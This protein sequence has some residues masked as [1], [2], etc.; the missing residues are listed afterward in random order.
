M[1]QIL[2]QFNL[3][4]ISW[5]WKASH[6][7]CLLLAF[8]TFS[9]VVTLSKAGMNKTVIDEMLTLPNYAEEFSMWRAELVMNVDVGLAGRERRSEICVVAICHAVQV[10]R[11]ESA[12]CWFCVRCFGSCEEGPLEFLPVRNAMGDVLS[13]ISGSVAQYVSLPLLE[14]SLNHRTGCVA[15]VDDFGHGPLPCL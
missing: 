2:R 13:L 5:S 10:R 1:G 8:I 4:C 6:W 15:K 14:N 9:S 12:S 7:K 11:F 3:Q